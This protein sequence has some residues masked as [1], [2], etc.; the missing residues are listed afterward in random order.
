[1]SIG[2]ANSMTEKG[3]MMEGSVIVQPPC[4]VIF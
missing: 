2:L 3:H 1:M 4:L